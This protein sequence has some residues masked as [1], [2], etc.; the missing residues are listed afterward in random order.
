MWAGQVDGEFSQSAAESGGDRHVRFVT[1]SDCSLNVAHVVLSPTG[2]DS[3]DNETKELIALGY[4]QPWRKYLVW[5][6]A[7]V[8]CGIASLAFDDSAKPTNANNVYSSYGRVDQGCWGRTDHLS[9]AHELM[10]GL[11][12]VQLSAPHSTGH[13]HCTDEYDVMCYADAAGVALI[14]PCVPEHEWLFD[15]QHDDYFNANP[16]AGSYLATHWNTARSEFLLDPN[17]PLA[18]IPSVVRAVSASPRDGAATVTWSIPTRNG[19]SPV[20]GYLV[21]SYGGSSAVPVQSFAPGASQIVNGLTNG[22]QYTFKVVAGNGV[23]LSQLSIASGA[24]VVGAPT[25]PSSTRAVKTSP[26]TL[27]VAFAEP[28]T[29]GAKIKT[30]TATCTSHNGG[31]TR[32]AS[33]NHNPI[34]VSGLTPGKTYTCTVRATNSRGTGPASTAS[35]AVKA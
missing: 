30:F 32:I 27:N 6:D 31:V 15:C 33:N 7:T 3:F 22:Q 14:Y 8:Y 23:G 5:T 21:N 34:A 25:A 17:A 24:I 10:H 13:G 26:G 11:G 28:S 18:T 2:D 29:N 35:S 9:E 4:D 20:T 1:N 16:A 12:G 19:G